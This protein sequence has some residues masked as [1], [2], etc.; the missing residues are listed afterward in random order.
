MQSVLGTELVYLMVNFIE[1]PCL[2]V[3][4]GVLL[5]RFPRSTLLKTVDNFNFVKIYENPGCSA[6]WDVNDLVRLKSDLN[7]VYSSYYRNHPV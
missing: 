4:K 7:L 1:D 6:T 3:F 5:Y 2:V